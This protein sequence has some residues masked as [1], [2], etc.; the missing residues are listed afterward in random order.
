[1]RAALVA[2]LAA[3]APPTAPPVD[4]ERARI[5]ADDVDPAMLMPTV[6]ALA[7][8]HLADEKLPCSEIPPRDGL[9][10]CDLSNAAARAEI[11][12]AFEDE[13]YLA[14]VIDH[15][16]EEPASSIV[17]EW[18]GT[19]KAGEVVLVGAHYDAF[20]AGADDNSSG[21]A[22]M[23]AIARAT[24][25]H[26]F[27]RTI[28]FV[29]FDLEERGSAGS[30]RYV[31]EGHA[32]DVR[33]ALILESIGYASTAARSQDSP[34]GLPLP[35]VGDFLLVVADGD[36]A[37]IAERLLALGA[38]IAELPV[39]AIVASARGPLAAVL[40]RSDNAPFW[41]A[42]IPAVMLTDT[43]EFRNHEYHEVGDTADRL[44]PAF[45]GAVTRTAAATV[46]ELAELVP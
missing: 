27:A 29:A 11:I 33:A 1:M 20:H 42:G 13:G 43:A 2:V 15:P 22:A 39:T 45:L 16:G 44:D 7:D 30:T 34:L 8:G 21:V 41:D 4:V 5:L 10:S 12:R 31:K 9:P 3:C 6:S 26:S 23:L 28:R 14:R 32:H 19:T 25:R 40:E 37:P 35:E 17:A 18:P 46:A 24:R 36:S 38:P